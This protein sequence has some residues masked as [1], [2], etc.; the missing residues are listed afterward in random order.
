MRNRD[1]RICAVSG[2]PCAQALPQ[3]ESGHRVEAQQ[4]FTV[5]SAM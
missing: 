5:D 3:C 1:A 2:C 4:S